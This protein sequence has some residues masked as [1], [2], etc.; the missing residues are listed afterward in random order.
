[1]EGVNTRISPRTKLDKPIELRI[2]NDTIRN[3]N[4][5]NNLSPTG[6]F[7]SHGNLPVGAAVRIRIQGRRV[8][9]AHGEIRCRH[10]HGHGVGISFTSISARSRAALDDLIEDLTLRGLPAA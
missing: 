8:F 1:M 2:G 10:P 6:L 7:I 9:E 3:A 5:A 4:P